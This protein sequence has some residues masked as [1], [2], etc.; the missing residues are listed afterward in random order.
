[1]EVEG[2]ERRARSGLQVS[3]YSYDLALANHNN[4]VK[5][6]NALLERRKEKYRL[7]QQERVSVNDMV[8]RYNRSER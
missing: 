6:Y 2:Y 5:Q 8:D 1:L 4:G 3:Q 7:Y